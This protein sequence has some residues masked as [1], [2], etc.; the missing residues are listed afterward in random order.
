MSVQFPYSSADLNT[1]CNGLVTS[2]NMNALRGKTYYSGTDGSLVTV[3]SS[4]PIDLG[5]FRAGMTKQAF[6]SG[7]PLMSP[8][9]ISGLQMWLDGNDPLASGVAPS[10]GSSI[11][12]YDK[13][14]NKN[15]T[16]GFGTGGGPTFVSGGGISF[17]GSSQFCRT[18]YTAHAPTES[19]F[20]VFKTNTLPPNDGASLK[21]LV[22][23]DTIGGRQFGLYSTNSS[24]SLAKNNVVWLSVGNTT[25]VIGNKYI[26]E[27]T[28]S[29]SGIS[30][31]ST[32]ND[33][34]ATNTNPTFSNGITLIGAGKN[35]QT[36]W[37][38]SGIIYEVLI[39]NK[40]VTSDERQN[41]EGYL[42]WKWGLQTNLPSTHSNRSSAPTLELQNYYGIA[43]ANNVWL[44]Y[45]PPRDYSNSL[46]ILRSK[47]GKYWVGI[48][49][50]RLTANYP[51]FVKNIIYTNN[52]RWI[53]SGHYRNFN[54]NESDFTHIIIESLD[55]GITWAGIDLLPKSNSQ[56]AKEYGMVY[57]N[58][59]LYII[60]NYNEVNSIWI[61]T[62]NYINGIE[63]IHITLE[64]YLEDVGNYYGSTN[65]IEFGNGVV[66]LSVRKTA[67]SPLETLGQPVNR[68][69]SQL[70]VT[71][72]YSI[73]EVSTPSG[74]VNIYAIKFSFGYWYMS[75]VYYDTVNY[76][77]RTYTGN[78][79][80]TNFTWTL[81]VN[82]LCGQKPSN[83]AIG[84][85][86]SDW[87]I[88]GGNNRFSL[89]RIV[90]QGLVSQNVFNGGS[91][92]GKSIAYGNG[93]F[94]QV[95]DN[96]DILTIYPSNCY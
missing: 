38:F 5:S 63:H 87:V 16:E 45:G 70:I 56:P 6:T 78:N 76:Y 46:N 69:N 74:L 34:A 86:G 60:F 41:I 19:I 9:Y 73:T 29:S 14:G 28:Y 22:D 7:K 91:G 47:E 79:S 18:E 64:H 61:Y 17:N 77:F 55:N 85:S 33:S 80:G 54:V 83:S 8:A 43:Y 20:V 90:N 39:Y 23:S 21:S 65:S 27:C 57:G 81:Q 1:V 37:H 30:I 42:A 53:A 84:Y 2:K 10:V 12:W 75:A 62:K 35:I 48:S 52:N 95:S 67:P 89:F 49:T 92:V 25:T 24:P 11:D 59:T 94:I 71:D 15:D 50:P 96:R 68:G 66:L 4:G 93:I 40:V 51:F 72:G 44:L 36:G 82:L 3:P 13:S 88:T 58:N 31:Y 26:A 32:G